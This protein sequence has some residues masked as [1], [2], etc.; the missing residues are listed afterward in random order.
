MQG[1]PSAGF[2]FFWL[3]P[4]KVDDAGSLPQSWRC[5]HKL[6]S[7][8]LFARGNVD[9]RQCRRSGALMASSDRLSE[10]R[11]LLEAAHPF[12]PPDPGARFSA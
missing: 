12:S 3:L 8:P 11:A 7:V 5:K 4:Q 1:P 9:I 10:S 6:L 2:C